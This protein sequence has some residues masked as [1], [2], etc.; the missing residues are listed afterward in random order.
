MLIVNKNGFQ[1]L[2][3]QKVIKAEEYAAYVTAQELIARAQAEADAL[4]QHSLEAY[5]AEKRRGY[6]EGLL[7]GK[8][9]MA[10]QMLD[11]ISGAVDYLASVEE[12]IIEVVM[13]AMKRILGE[14][15][16]GELISR[17]VKNGLEVARNQK[18][19]TVRVAPS[20]VDS[21]RDRLKDILLHFPSINF[22]DVAPDARLEVG[23]CIMETEMG[24]VDAS[25]DVQLAAIRKSLERRIKKNL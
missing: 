5:E 17:I 20:Q 3:E 8:E 4:K 25:I 23:G 15:D 21:V 6:E 7:E 22:I 2:P 24:F 11:S 18:Q 19:V 16:E 9:Q 13:K 12:K 1:P 14:M 10:M